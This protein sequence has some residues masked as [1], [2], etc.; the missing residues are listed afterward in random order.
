MIEINLGN[1]VRAKIVSAV[2]GQLS[3]GYWENSPKMNKYWR[4]ARVEGIIL[5]CNDER[6]DSGFSGKS[7]EDIKS[8]FASK[9]KTVVQEE[10]GNNKSG[11][12]RDNMRISDYISYNN[13]ITVSHCYECYD[14]LK[15]RTG[16]TY[17]FQLAENQPEYVK[18]KTT[19]TNILKNSCKDLD[20]ID[21]EDLNVW[22]ESIIAYYCSYH[23]ELT[24]GGFNDKWFDDIDG[25]L[26]TE[27]YEFAWPRTGAAA[28][29][30]DKALRSNSN[31]YIEITQKQGLSMNPED[32]IKA[33][34]FEQIRPKIF[35]G[36]R[37]VLTGEGD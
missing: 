11:W 2:I 33:T 22:I 6:W 19:I 28:E 10:V 8:W 35:E 13:D 34:Y 23:S 36:M 5:K 26:G 24:K 27:K 1:P 25:K 18:F 7:E 30:L 14:W 15:G 32:C 29:I 12:S 21:T 3:D 16:H 9:L 17:A 4:F 37:K 31:Y 20:W